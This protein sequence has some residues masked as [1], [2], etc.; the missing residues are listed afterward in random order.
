MIRS[1]KAIAL[2]VS[3]VALLMGATSISA[4]ATYLGY[5]NGDPGNWDLWTEQNNGINPDDARPP[6]VR[7]PMHHRHAA[8]IHHHVHARHHGYR[9]PQLPGDLP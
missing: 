3:S 2:T 7:Q 8:T 9:A 1:F 4:S 6:Q 5:G